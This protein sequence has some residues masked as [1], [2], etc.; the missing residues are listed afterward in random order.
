MVTKTRTSRRAATGRGRALQVS[1]E[2]PKASAGRT[3]DALTDFIRPVTEA[4]GLVG[5]KIALRRQATLLEI[6]K[7]TR[8]RLALTR[9]SVKPIPPKFLVPLLEKASLEDLSNEK[10]IKMWS[11]LLATAA[12][13]EVELI[14]QYTTILSEITSDQVKLMEQILRLSDIDEPEDAG[15]FIDNYYM[16]NQSGLPG[17]IEDI[18]QTEDISLFADALATH[19]DISGVAL[20]TI[21]IYFQD[22]SKQESTSIVSPDGVY[23]DSRFY[24]FENLIRLG[25]LSKS[26][27]KRFR[28]GIFDIDVIYYVVTPVGVDLYACCNPTKLIREARR[29]PS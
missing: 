4:F 10:L 28:I 25:L 26:E 8:E 18:A 23:R 21:N 13:E 7:K 19:F 20:D 24:D 17:R 3:V 27:V 6:A 22:A 12:T 16:L 15:V 11:N 2:I 29:A 9:Q 5:D 1:V 14:G